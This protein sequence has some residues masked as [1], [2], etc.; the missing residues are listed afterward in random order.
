M[1]IKTRNINDIAAWCGIIWFV[2][3]IDASFTWFLSYP[4]RVFIGSLFILYVTIILYRKKE[5]VV[6][7]HRLILLIT[8]FFLL[9]FRVFIKDEFLVTPFVFLPLMCIVQWNRNIMYKWYQLFRKFIIFYAILSIIIEFLVLSGVWKFLPYV[10]IP[11]QDTVQESLNLEN[12]FY[13]L[14]SISVPDYGLT[15]YRASGPLREGGHFAVYLGFLYFVETIVYLKRNIWLIVCGFLTLSPNFVSLFII[16]EGYYA[17][18]NKRIIK[19]L[20][21]L[22]IFFGAVIMAFVLSPQAIKDEIVRVVLER[23][24]ENSLNNVQYDGFMAILD[25]RTNTIGIQM[26]KAFVKY[27]TPN[28]HLIGYDPS[29]LTEGYVLSDI[30][31]LIIR[32]GYVGLFLIALCTLL[33]SK[34]SQTR[35]YGFLLFIMAIC[36]MLQRAWMFDFAY[37]WVMMFLAT[38]VKL[39]ATNSKIY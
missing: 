39:M 35:C 29:K 21:G 6:S 16:T 20:A 12:Y 24:L 33:F 2:F 10:I 19:A 1:D 38:N 37:I 28:D 26:Y 36:V 22:V 30:R 9:S 31:Y 14:F 27:G 3:I 5:L 32:Y 7:R 15:F 4:K 8:I 13:G 17:F 11:P 25:G 23:T 18:L 34:G